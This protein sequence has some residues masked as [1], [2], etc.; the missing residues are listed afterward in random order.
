MSFSAFI[1]YCSPGGST[2]TAARMIGDVFSDKG[3]PVHTFDIGSQDD[4][5]PFLSKLAA[6]GS[7]ALLCVGSPVY[8][9]LAVPPV[10]AFIDALSTGG[11]RAL[12]FVTWGKACSGLALWQMGQALINRGFNLVGA[13]K[14]LGVHSMMWRDAD[15]VGKGHPGD[16]DRAILAGGLSDLIA[17]IEANTVKTLELEVLSYLPA[18]LTDPAK[19]RIGEPWVAMG[20]TVNIETC[21]QCGLCAEACPVSAIEL[22]PHPVFLSHCFGCFRCMRECPEN[23]IESAMPLDQ[24]AGMI[25]KRVATIAETPDT[26]VFLP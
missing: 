16:E 6:A 22:D 21:T 13:A 20:K 25:R 2:R 19:A 23:A 12:P 3:V 14:V 18:A 8:K 24:L 1:A 7:D 4:P 15:P 10:T 17:A 11:A 5:A 9:D 26:C